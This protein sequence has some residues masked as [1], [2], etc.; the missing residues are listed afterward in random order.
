MRPAGTFR[1]WLL[2]GQLRLRLRCRARPQ[3]VSAPAVESR[4]AHL[5][6]VRQDGNTDHP[7]HQ[8]PPFRAAHFRRIAGWTMRYNDHGRLRHHSRIRGSSLYQENE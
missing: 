3:S 4:L 2:P 8:V 7:L 1:R 6:T 5:A